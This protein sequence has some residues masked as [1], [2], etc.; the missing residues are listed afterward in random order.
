V[1]D[2]ESVSGKENLSHFAVPPCAKLFIS[3][4]DT[5]RI[6]DPRA[7]LKQGS[8]TNFVKIPPFSKWK[9]KH[10]Q[11]LHRGAK[12]DGRRQDRSAACGVSA[13]NEGVSILCPKLRRRCFRIGSQA[14]GRWLNALAFSQ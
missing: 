12:R 14:F 4:Q 3:K 11:P 2:V 13:R 6:N 1:E 7:L 8:K 10:G 5:A 9:K